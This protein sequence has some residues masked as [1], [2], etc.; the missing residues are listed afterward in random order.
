M[1]TDL[2]KRTI[3]INRVDVG[4]DFDEMVVMSSLRDDVGSA[5]TNPPPHSWPIGPGRR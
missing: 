3:P 4:G 1:S 5:H 2:L